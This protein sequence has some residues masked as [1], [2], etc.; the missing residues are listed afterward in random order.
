M[1]VLTA[2][3]LKA[4][5]MPEFTMDLG[6]GREIV[7]RRPDFQLLVL[8]GLLPTPLLSEMVKL[9]GEW[10][11]A[12]MNA[13]TEDLIEKNDKLLT[14]VNT[15]VCHAMVSPRVVATAAEQAAL[16][17]DALLPEDLSL[18]TKRRI[19]I[20]CAMQDKATREVVA[21]AKDFPEN[22]HG[23]GSGPDVPPLQDP[24]V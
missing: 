12:D 4:M 22:G 10:A 2:T 15:Y 14:F 19:V 5:E 6:G 17:G 16:G 23:T 21:A 11:A 24:P 13:L 1:A 3:E 20:R 8:K 7:V 9:V 18:V